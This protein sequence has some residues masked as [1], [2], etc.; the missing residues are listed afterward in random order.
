MPEK[1]SPHRHDS[2][3]ET[4]RAILRVAEDLFMEHGYRA[5]STRK[6]AQYTGISQPTLYYHFSDKQELYVAVMLAVLNRIQIELEH[7]ATASDITVEEKLKAVIRHILRF[8]KDRLKVGPMLRDIEAELHETARN[9]VSEAFY[10]GM[11]LPVVT[12]LQQNKTPES[13]NGEHTSGLSYITLAFMF[14]SMIST[15]TEDSNPLEQRKSSFEESESEIATKLTRFYL[16]G[17][18]A[19][20]S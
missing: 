9:N 7:I 4:R 6:V 11:I 8:S 13:S 1:R 5:V 19:G 17:L 2:T 3:E 18:L 15:L 12:I 14:Y 16:H 20:Q 10:K